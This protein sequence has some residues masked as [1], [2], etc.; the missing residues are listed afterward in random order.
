MAGV[1]KKQKVK[2]EPRCLYPGVNGFHGCSVVRALQEDSRGWQVGQSDGP[3][4]CVM[5]Q[6]KL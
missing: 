3:L 6:K 4:S 5:E 1:S 2:P